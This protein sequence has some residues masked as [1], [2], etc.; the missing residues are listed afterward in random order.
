MNIKKPVASPRTEP[1]RLS[2]RAAIAGI[3]VLP[4]ALPGAGAAE[5]DPIFEVIERHRKLSDGYSAAVSI[6]AKLDDGP[7]FDVADKISGERNDALLKHAAAMIRSEPTTMAGIAILLRYAANLDNWQVPAD[8]GWHQVF[9]GTL[10]DA[11]DG[12]LKQAKR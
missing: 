7:D 12:I 2:R 4:A 5:L 6:S 8:D 3:A 11:L 1:K 10:A 9:L